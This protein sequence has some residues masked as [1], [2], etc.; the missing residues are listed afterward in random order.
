MVFT[1]TVAL[2]NAFF[3]LGLNPIDMAAAAPERLGAAERAQWGSY[4]EHLP[5]V[6]FGNI[7]EGYSAL[8]H[9]A[10]RGDRS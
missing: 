4:Y 2:R 5:R 3:R 6:L 7:A 8:T 1:G 10:A 9:N